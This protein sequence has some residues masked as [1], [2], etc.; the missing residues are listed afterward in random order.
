MFNGK[1][2]YPGHGDQGVLNAVLF[3]ESAIDRVM[4]LDNRLWSQ[5]WVYWSS[6]FDY[7]D[8]DFVNISSGHQPQRAFHCGGAEKYWTKEHRQRILAD[9]SLQTYPYIWFLTMHWFGYCR[10]WSVD[11]LQ[12]LP[13]A[14]HHLVT[15]LVHFFPQILQVYPEARA[16]WEDLTDAMIDRVLD[17][18]P[19]MLSL[20]G[21]SMSEVIHLVASNPSVRRYV[22][23]GGYEGGSILAL[24]LRFANRDIDFYSVDLLWAT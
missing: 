22:E 20:G 3:S 14:S 15:D 1:G 8:G 5:H 9:H 13:P 7:R 10:D 18:I 12:Y 17:G 21:R 6:I 23:I 19:R 16:I 24:G 2:A 11:P 4:L